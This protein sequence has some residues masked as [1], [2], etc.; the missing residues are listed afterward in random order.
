MTLSLSSNVSVSILVGSEIS[1]QIRFRD[2][3]LIIVL[4]HHF[5]ST[6]VVMYWVSLLYYRLE[7]KGRW[8]TSTHLGRLERSF[9]VRGSDL[10]AVHYKCFG[11]H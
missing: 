7:P 10:V 11:R 9:A 2:V 8:L 1:L 4:H 6:I 5:R 3:S